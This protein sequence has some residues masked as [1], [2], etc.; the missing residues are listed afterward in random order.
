[1][2]FSR[3]EKLINKLIGNKISE[4]ELAELLAGITD[5][6]ERKAYADALEIYFNRLLNENRPDNGAEPK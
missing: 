2:S 5:E 4:G 3:A 6:E 1:M